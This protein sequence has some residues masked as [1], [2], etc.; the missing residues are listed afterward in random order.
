[1]SAYGKSLW[2]EAPG[3]LGGLR[4]QTGHSLD[5]VLVQQAQVLLEQPQVALQGVLVEGQVQPGPA[6]TQ[7]RASLGGRSA[8]AQCVCRAWAGRR[9]SA[10]EGTT[11]AN[12]LASSWRT[13]AL[14]PLFSR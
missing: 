14:K 7:G 10:G 3:Q 2:D 12:S 11:H 4:G 13:T 6:C 8:R 5:V 1:M 9:D